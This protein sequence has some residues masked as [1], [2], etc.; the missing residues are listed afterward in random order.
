MSTGSAIDRSRQ[1]RSD[2]PES[3]FGNTS[4]PGEPISAALVSATRSE[5]RQILREIADL[6]QQTLPHGEYFAEFLRRVT[7]ALASVGGAVWTVEEQGRLRIAARIHASQ[8]SAENSQPTAPA[9]SIPTDGHL[10]TLQRVI[11]TRQSIAI[12]PH[13]V[14]SPSEL[15]NAS[16]YLLLLVPL[17]VE[18]RVVGL[19][20]VSQRPHR[21][22]ATE[23]G[24]LSYLVQTG[25]LAERYLRSEYLRRLS[26]HRE[27]SDELER[28]LGEIHRQLG[29]D[30]TAFAVVNE[31]R[32]LCGVERVS[33]ALGHGGACRLK[34]VS[35]LDNVDR[36]AEQ[37]RQLARLASRV[38]KGRE[39]V[40]L[41][42]NHHDLP[43][44]IEKEWNRY[45]DISHVKRCAILPLQPSA[46]RD[47]QTCE[48][49]PFGVLIFEQLIE[50]VPTEQQD[51]R[52]RQLCRHSAGALQNALRYEQ[53][54]LLPVWRALG[55]VC[56]ALGGRHFS[57]TL[58]AAVLLVACAMT[59][60]T[61]ETDFAIPARGKMQPVLRRTIFAREDGV[62]TRVPVEHG[63]S[64]K[65]GD[66]LAEMRNTD[67]EVEITSLVGKQIATREQILS[68]QRTLLDDPRLDISQQNRLSGELLQ[69]KQMA[70]SIERQL[71]LVRQ[72]E[73]QLV[74]RADRDGQ[75]VTW[76]VRDNLLHRP[77]Q[78]GQALM[79]VV[80]PAA[81]W[82]LELY[83]P[84]RYIGHV[85]DRVV[86]GHQ[87]PPV[88]FVLSSQAGQQCAG[89]LV[90]VDPVA[91]A[92][93]QYGSTVRIRVAIDKGAVS[94]L[95]TDAT[96]VAKVHCG[97][98]S[99]GYA[100][101][102][103]LI[104]T[105]RSRVLFWL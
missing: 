70:E 71:E 32:R 63:Q 11:A 60:I 80:D 53:L 25:E 91:V 57:K 19:I 44:Q 52:I 51:R 14:A 41:E 75:V 50:A 81:N 83:V 62:I 74:V 85:L 4:L 5:V 24:Y 98:R 30:E 56:E 40:F 39:P 6:S 31:A 26:E 82:E 67:L 35:G 101:F 27:W 105:L 22:P 94:Q 28:F 7:T 54:F 34:T 89:Q 84:E 61:V 55:K 10:A 78:K 2:P 76:H 42:S 59:L 29:V 68:L 23:R 72:K 58:A 33:L 102:H 92:R 95:R 43:P 18:G 15:A 38:M 46:P 37:V 87:G 93:E 20:E 16:D 79:A 3:A 100:W 13:T 36:R 49:E 9:E 48:S 17:Q 64:V 97:Q 8:Y 69:L 1:F 103:D 45:V 99:L 21:G 47:D 86:D 104:D 66:V 65:S 90:A 73:E 96:V 88:T 77:I 12:P